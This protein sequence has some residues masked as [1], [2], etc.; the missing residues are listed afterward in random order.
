LVQRN[1]TEQ[2][3]ETF[4]AGEPYHATCPEIAP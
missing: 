1:L 4:L 2:E 3:W